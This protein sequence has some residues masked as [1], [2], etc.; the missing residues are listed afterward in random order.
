MYKGLVDEVI[1]QLKTLPELVDTTDLQGNPS[2]RVYKF[3]RAR[4][5]KEGEY[6]VEV[7][8]GQMTVSD[9][10]TKSTDNE[11]SIIC[12]LIHY[13]SEFETGF[14]SALTVAEKIYD[15][16]HLTTVNAKCRNAVVTLF[17]GD[18][19]LSDNS[20]LAI[21][22]RIIVTCKRVIHQT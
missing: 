12:D 7:K 1:T 18:G 6:E 4:K 5:P 20:L 3:N 11:F 19:E 14:D 2:P 13:A 10:T 8:A 9:F 15:K 22:I 16:V 17:P 21:P